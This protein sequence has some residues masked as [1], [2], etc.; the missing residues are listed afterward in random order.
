MDVD[1]LIA[2]QFLADYGL[3]TTTDQRSSNYLFFI[4]FLNIKKKSLSIVNF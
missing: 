4:F 1:H 3:S 2:I